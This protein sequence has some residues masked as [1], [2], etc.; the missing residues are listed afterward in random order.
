VFG[1]HDDIGLTEDERRALEGYADV[2]IIEIAGAG[3]FTLNQ[4]PG[5]IA[6]VVLDALG[7][8]TKPEEEAAS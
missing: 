1:E 3:H 6:D 7:L 2:K 4:E 5:K 8:S